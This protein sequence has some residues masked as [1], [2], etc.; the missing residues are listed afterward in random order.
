M[1]VRLGDIEVAY[2]RHGE[3]SPVVMAHGLA[4]DRRS[5]AD[6]QTRLSEFATYAYDFRGHGETTLGEGEGALE[7]LGRDLINFLEAVT[8]P[9]RCV[10]YSLGGAIVLWTAAERPDL[11][12]QAIVAGTSTVV[13]RTAAGFFHDRIGLIETDF[14]RFAAALRDDTA[15]QIVSAQVD[16]DEIVARRLR[17]IGDG[18]GYVNAARAMQRLHEA[19][20]TPRLPEIECSVDI[21]GGDADVFCPRKAAEIILSGLRDGAYHEIANAGHLI[22]I[23]QPAAYAEAITSALHRSK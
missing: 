9:A 6:V 1:K 11:V 16:L 4:E 5:W 3:G 12:L 13:G 8:G 18:G 7:Q 14:E 20:L 22:S 15:Q 10:G 23:D 21:I 17:A 2:T 19:P